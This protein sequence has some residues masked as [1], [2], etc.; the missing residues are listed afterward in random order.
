[1]CNNI[2][3]IKNPKLTDLKHASTYNGSNLSDW[4]ISNPVGMDILA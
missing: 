1:M 4:D 2:I 3:A